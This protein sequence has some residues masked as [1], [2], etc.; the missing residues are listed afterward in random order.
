[1]ITIAIYKRAGQTYSHTFPGKVYK[2][3]VKGKL[4]N[5]GIGCSEVLKVE[6][7]GAKVH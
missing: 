4:I 7:R 3:Q 5:L 6:H 2:D 1:M